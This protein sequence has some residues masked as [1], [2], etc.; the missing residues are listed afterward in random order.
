VIGRSF[1]SLT[2]LLSRQR[3]DRDHAIKAQDTSLASN[4]LTP[5]LPQEAYKLDGV[6]IV[7]SLFENLLPVRHVNISAELRSLTRS[8]LVALI[9]Y[10][11]PTAEDL[12]SMH[13]VEHVT[14]GTAKLGK[15]DC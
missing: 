1:E 6:I 7:R 13:C 4:V 8:H 10:S 15:D 12:T 14:G 11:R 2:V 9:L 3:E 5:W